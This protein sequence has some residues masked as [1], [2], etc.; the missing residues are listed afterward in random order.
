[1]ERGGGRGKG[2]VGGREVWIG[3]SG[4][5]ALTNLAF[6]SRPQK[7]E[8]QRRGAWDIHRSKY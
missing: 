1:M 4:L 3:P 8:G 7:G 5:S 2:G 6:I